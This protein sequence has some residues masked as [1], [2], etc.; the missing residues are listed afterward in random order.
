[1]N[2]LVELRILQKNHKSFPL[3]IPPIK[4]QSFDAKVLL[5]VIA[6]YLYFQIETL[7]SLNFYKDLFRIERLKRLKVQ[8]VKKDQISSI[9]GVLLPHYPSF[10]FFFIKRLGLSPVIPEGL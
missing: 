7:Y 9:V 10:G 5:G 4:G 2:V 6:A 1:M 3:Q 8:S